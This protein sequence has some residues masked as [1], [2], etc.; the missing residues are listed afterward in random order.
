M[1]SSPTVVEH[2]VMISWLGLF[3]LTLVFDSIAPF[4]LLIETLSLALYMI[5]SNHQL[6]LL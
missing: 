2:M 5:M 6:N 4:V 1:N 3:V